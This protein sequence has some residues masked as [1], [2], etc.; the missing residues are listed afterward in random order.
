MAERKNRS[1]SPDN[2]DDEISPGCLSSGSVIVYVW[3]Q[4]DAEALAEQLNGA[5]VEG[6]VVFY[7][8]GLEQGQRQRAQGQVN[9]FKCLMLMLMPY[10]L[11]KNRRSLAFLLQF[12]R[13]K[14][15]ICV[16][17]VAFGMGTFYKDSHSFISL[18]TCTK[19]SLFPASRCTLC[20]YFVVKE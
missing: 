14:A 16:A 11:T 9:I 13:G 7:H 6:G 18:K 3:R 2:L 12:M 19:A 17:T 4:R 20:L 1:F 5:G 10:S 15:R 8:G